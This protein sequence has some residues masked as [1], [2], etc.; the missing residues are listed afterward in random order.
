VI[1]HLAAVD[2]DP[3][4]QIFPC[5]ARPTIGRV[6]AAPARAAMNSRRLGAGRALRAPRWH[7]CSRGVRSGAS[8]RFDDLVRPFLVANDLTN[9]VVI[10][11]DHADGNDERGLETFELSGPTSQFAI[12]RRAW[13]EVALLEI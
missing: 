7:A 2:L 3:M 1:E 11:L 10:A 9:T 13:Q 6:L 12:V 5:C 8:V 4:R